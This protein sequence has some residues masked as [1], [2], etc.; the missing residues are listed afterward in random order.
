MSSNKQDL[1]STSVVDPLDQDALDELVESISCRNFKLFKIL[2]NHLKP[3]WIDKPHSTSKISPLETVFTRYPKVN[4]LDLDI[5]KALFEKGADLG[6]VRDEELSRMMEV[7]EGDEEEESN[8]V[9]EE[10][11]TILIE[12]FAELEKSKE[13]AIGEDVGPE[14]IKLEENEEIPHSPHSSSNTPNMLQQPHE[15]THKAEIDH[16]PEHSSRKSPTTSQQQ[17]HDSPTIPHSARSISPVPSTPNSFPSVP[18]PTISSRRR[19]APLTPPESIRL[20]IALPPRT[21]EQYFTRYFERTLQVPIRNVSLTNRGTLSFVHLEVDRELYNSGDLEKKISEMEKRGRYFEDTTRRRWDLRPKLSD[22]LTDSSTRW[23]K[24]EEEESSS[25][26]SKRASEE[27]S[28]Y[29][30]SRS[31]QTSSSANGRGG[32]GRI[33]EWIGLQI[34]GF[35]TDSNTRE[36]EKTLSSFLDGWD[37]L[38]IKS[39]GF[40]VLVLLNVDGEEKVKAAIREGSKIEFDGKKLRI[41]R[42]FPEVFTQAEERRKR[43]RSSEALPKLTR[44]P[45]QEEEKEVRS[46]QAP[47]VSHEDRKEARSRQQ[48]TTSQDRGGGAEW[49][50]LKIRSFPAEYTRTRVEETLSSF[51]DNWKDIEMWTEGLGTAL[52]VRVQGEEAVSKAIMEGSNVVVAGKKLQITRDTSTFVKRKQPEVQ[53]LDV[54][55]PKDDPPPIEESATDAVSRLRKKRDREDKEEEKEHRRSRDK[56]H[57]H[58]PHSPSRSKPTSSR[59][60]HRSRSTSPHRKDKPRKSDHRSKEPSRSSHRSSKRSQRSRSRSRS[61]SPNTRKLDASPRRSRHSRS[62]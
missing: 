48:S 59:H 37:R 19:P 38:Q 36:I 31:L 26:R 16:L 3:E 8:S 5:L 11:E 49:I 43:E 46:D 28:K 23:R 9:K 15:E 29:D 47:R 6:K 53:Q 58:R 54:T 12:R 7:E 60:R 57:H 32:G 20:Y 27:R 2:L 45:K 13:E 30:P 34:R 41:V 52:V 22:N 40:G 42:E 51:L 24:Q 35:S 50:S 56:K 44:H 14:A 62:Q 33:E 1:S 25:S 61:R 18:P 39:E 4:S 55:A 17:E 21:T 10:F